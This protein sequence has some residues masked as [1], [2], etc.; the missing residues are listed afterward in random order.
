MIGV[1]F[2][3]RAAAAVVGA[4]FG[5]SGSAIA[6]SSTTLAADVDVAPQLRSPR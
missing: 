5:I 3:E 1:A 2:L 4:N 6:E